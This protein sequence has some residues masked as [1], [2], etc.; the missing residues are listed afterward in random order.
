MG[1]VS[2][3]I[4]G[5]AVGLIVKLSGGIRGLGDWIACV[6]LGAAAGVLGGFTVLMFRWGALQEF[7]LGSTAVAAVTALV[8]LLGY[9]IAE[10]QP[11]WS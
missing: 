1:F 3:L 10:R 9:R 7:G 4:A 8:V 2:W 5:I 11:R 6:A